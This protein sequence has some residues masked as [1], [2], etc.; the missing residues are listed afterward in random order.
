MRFFPTTST[1]ERLRAVAAKGVILSGG[2]ESVTVA[3]GVRAPPSVFELGV[4]VLGICYGMQTMAAQ[5]GGDVEMGAHREFG[6]ARVR[7]RGHS[8]LLRDIEDHTTPEGYALLDVWMSHGDRVNA[9]PEGFKVIASTD[10]API[11]GIADESRRFYGV[12]FHPRSPTRV[13]ATGSCGVSCTTSA[14]ASSY[15]PRATSSRTASPACASRSTRSR[16]CWRSRAVWTRRWSRPC[17]ARRSASADLHLRGPRAVAAQRGRA[18]DDHLQAQM[19]V[20]VVRV[21]AE[22]RFLGALEGV[23]D[24]ERKRKIIGNLF[25]ETFEQESAKLRT[26]A[27]W[28]RAPSTPM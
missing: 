13:R 2:P 25:I 23:E 27:G 6:Y 11:A 3:D 8:R 9:M 18:G 15:G 5:L 28:P 1:T 26:C 16:C 17:S 10:N 7:A 21:D 4:P 19:G 14:R 12:Q 22:E 24:P 20:N